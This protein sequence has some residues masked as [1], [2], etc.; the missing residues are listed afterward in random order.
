VE[1]WERGLVL[2]PDVMWDGN[3][4]FKFVIRGILDSHFGKD[5]ETR[6]SV[7]GN[8]TFLYGE[9]VIQRSTMQICPMHLVTV[10]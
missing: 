10:K 6:K 2:K 3:P 5:P 1:T 7:S 4:E 8:S 9:P